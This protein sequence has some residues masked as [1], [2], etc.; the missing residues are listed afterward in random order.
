MGRLA[1]RT[2][3]GLALLALAIVLVI[4]GVRMWDARRGPPLEPWHVF[5]PDDVTAEEIE[6]LDWQGYVADEAR[7]FEAVRQEAML[8]P[9]Q[10]SGKGMSRYI[11]G[12]P[13][14]PAGF[15]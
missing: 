3:R 10:A 12:T 4:V 2:G 1:W 8:D 5:V 9:A 14:D 11:R 7:L 15:K 6:G 13:I